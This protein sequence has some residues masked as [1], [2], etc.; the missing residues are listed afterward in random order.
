[1]L[2]LIERFGPIGVVDLADRAGRDY[3]TVSRQVAKLESLELVMRKTDAHDARLRKSA[4]APKGKR[5]TLAVDAARARIGR[6]IFKTW[7]P[8]DLAELVRL[9]RQFADAIKD[10]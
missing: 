2:V 9:T 6:R 7:D 8:H 5:M 3:T 4:I 10:A 1:L